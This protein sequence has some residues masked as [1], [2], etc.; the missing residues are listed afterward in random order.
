[1]G[2][3]LLGSQIAKIQAG[4]CFDRI[5]VA[6]LADQSGH[7]WLRHAAIKKLPGGQ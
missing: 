4:V 1:L 5:F 6:H 7:K 3:R 2:R